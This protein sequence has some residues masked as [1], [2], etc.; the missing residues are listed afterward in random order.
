MIL[1]CSEYNF[2]KFAINY[3]LIVVYVNKRVYRRT[4][5]EYFFYPYHKLNSF[6]IV[7]YIYVIYIHP[8]YTKITD[9]T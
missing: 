5:G 6:I 4:R 3:K 8:V 1:K 7:T 9:R 2:V